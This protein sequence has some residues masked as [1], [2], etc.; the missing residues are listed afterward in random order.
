MQNK[1]TRKVMGLYEVE[2]L[3]NANL[4]TITI[5][6]KEYFE[7]FKDRKINKKHKGVRRDTP[8]MTFESYAERISSLRQLDTK[9]EKKINTKKITG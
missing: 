5:N 9:P 1:G 6:S 7:K 8:G 2:N 4:Y 3:D